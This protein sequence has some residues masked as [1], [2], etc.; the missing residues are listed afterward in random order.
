MFMPHAAVSL[1]HRDGYYHVML[2][3][4]AELLG[5]AVIIATGV[6]YRG[7]D[8]S[9]IEKFEGLSVFYSPSHARL[10]NLMAQADRDEGGLLM[11]GRTLDA[12]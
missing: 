5:K 9:G 11:H 1:S 7:L 4:H 12:P 10:P 2:Q 6:S 3:N 8:V